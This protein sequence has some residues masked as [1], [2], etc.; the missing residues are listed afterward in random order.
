MT[1][2]MIHAHNRDLFMSTKTKPSQKAQSAE[3]SKAEV[4]RTMCELI[5]AFY[6][7]TALEGTIVTLVTRIF[8]A[9]K[10]FEL[11]GPNVLADV[12][13]IANF[14][15]HTKRDLQGKALEDLQE[16]RS[17]FRAA[18]G[19]LCSPKNADDVGSPFLSY[20]KDHGLNHVE[21]ELEL[22]NGKLVLDTSH[23]HLIDSFCVFLVGECVG[24]PPSMMPIKLC[25][26]CRQLF[27]VVSLKGQARIRKVHCSARCQ[28]SSHWTKTRVARA[29]LQYVSRLSDEYSRADRRRRLDNPK[30]KIRLSEIRERWAGKWPTLMLKLK[31]AI[32]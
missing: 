6:N 16:H 11:R 30:V 31:Q 4:T 24:V 2:N 1:M 26:R 14:L 15:R 28:E 27:S 9:A 8:S 17:E 3:Q 18:V 7:G 29:D 32:S 10:A 23:L 5:A 19:W 13:I 25:S 20:F 21:R 22:R 12:M